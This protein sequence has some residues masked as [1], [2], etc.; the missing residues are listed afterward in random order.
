ML[1]R[2]SVSGVCGTDL[3]LAS[4]HLGPTAEILGHEGVGTIVKLGSG[5]PVSQI[6][7]GQKVGIAW[8][9]DIC[10][11]CHYCLAPGGETRCIEQMNSGRK[12]NGTFAEFAVVPSRY[13]IRLP[14][15]DSSI[16][17]EMIAPIL[18]GG[19][20]AYK[21][22][23]ICDAVPGQWV[24][25]SG[26]GGGVGA[27]GVQYARAMGYRVI[28][29]DAGKEKE[30]F[31]K[32]SGADSYI[33]VLTETDTGKAVMS[34]TEGHGAKAVIVTAGAGRAYQSALGMLAP[35][36]TLVCVGIPPPDQ[37]VSFHPLLFI[38][39][40][41][42]IVGSAV[43]TRGEIL[44]ALEFV[45]RGVVTP[46]V[47]VTALSNLSQIVK[48]FTKVRHMGISLSSMSDWCECIAN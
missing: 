48:D 16:R 46:T 6:Q 38:D 7:L 42:R 10:G 37:L 43:G 30:G 40:G 45:R 29:I 44:E 33:D 15:E 23:K 24:V 5:V 2:L 27:L 19:V 21:A 31:C 14:K 18:C 3:A 20:T 11:D 13:I 9:R 22:L 4:G 26:A 35:F 34:L 1:V 36:G 39:K 25:I 41:I 17:D 32:T 8:Q 28:A 12:I 47:H